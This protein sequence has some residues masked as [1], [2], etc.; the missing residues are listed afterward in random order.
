MLCFE[1]GAS[2]LDAGELKSHFESNHKNK[3]FFF[4]SCGDLK[5]SRS[6]STLDLLC[7]HVALKHNQSMK[8][9]NYK[10]DSNS[11]ESVTTPTKTLH[12]KNNVPVLKTLVPE[13]QVQNQNV[14]EQILDIRTSMFSKDYYQSMNNIAQNLDLTLKDIY[15]ELYADAS[16]PKK[17][18]QFFHNSI[19]KLLKTYNGGIS[20][21]INVINRFLKNNGTSLCGVDFEN[22]SNVSVDHTLKKYSTETRR[23]N[24][25]EPNQGNEIFEFEKVSILKDCKVVEIGGSLDI[26]VEE[27]TM[28]HIPLSQTLV[29]VL[30]LPNMLKEIKAYITELIE[31][32]N[33][34]KVLSNFVQGELWRE[35]MNYH[36][37]KTVL[38]LFFYFD[39]FQAKNLNGSQSLKLK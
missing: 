33:R 31:D 7:Q 12:D 37:G 5:C 16:C 30:S 10:D 4:F 14:P 21:H 22:I 32:Y 28:Q 25:I 1:C 19:H 26:V 29:K 9:L 38:P 24:A 23:L 39:D 13:L 36:H 20:E 11:F 18:A 3:K 2:Y 34:T 6:F 17:V 8:I 15:S 27:Q 35:R